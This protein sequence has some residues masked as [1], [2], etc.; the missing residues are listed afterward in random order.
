MRV[1][2]ADVVIGINHV[3]KDF[4]LPIP[5]GVFLI[6]LI[7]NYIFRDMVKTKITFSDDFI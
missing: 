1:K 2:V 3:L 5:N 7:C 6:S 4:G